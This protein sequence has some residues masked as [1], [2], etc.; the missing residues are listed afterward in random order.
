MRIDNNG[1]VGIGTNYPLAKL[2][3]GSGTFRLDNG[4]TTANYFATMSANYN[5]AHP[6]QINVE[7]NTGGTASEV[8]GIYSPGGGGSLNP[9]FPLNGATGVGI[10][11]TSPA[12][13]LD[14][15]TTN[16]AIRALSSSGTG[17]ANFRLQNN[18]GQTQ[19]FKDDSTGG[20]FSGVAYASGIYATGAYPFMLYTNS[21]ERMRIDSFGN[22]LVGSTT[23]TTAGYRM[24]IATGNTNYSLATNGINGFIY[25]NNEF[26]FAANLGQTSDIYINYRAST[27]GFT[28]SG[29]R[30]LN[31]GPSTYVP[32]YAS[33]FT[34]TSDYR[35]KTNVQPMTSS[36]A[37]ISKL[38]P[39][40][41]DW[42]ADGTYS[43]GFIA[44]EVQE[45]APYAVHG[46]KDAV[47]P[48]KG[49]VPQGLDSAKL[50]ARLTGALQEL[51]AKLK[52]LEARFAA[53]ME[54][55]P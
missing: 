33:A 55:H 36:L 40:T 19:L 37:W 41:F 26:D 52:D 38:R 54:A 51:E 10:G 5:S 45:I 3:L 15:T 18:G 25:S 47:D 13:A 8:M 48:D 7:N 27:G 31:A 34:V 50:V 2:N 39:V 12:Y 23:S 21:A 24:V 11:T 42:T 46:E 22:V 14:V 43:E 30:F 53:Y 32:L 4:T 1:N 6:F 28:V 29:Y 17:N 20:S 9:C 44:H 35:L 16:A 49:L